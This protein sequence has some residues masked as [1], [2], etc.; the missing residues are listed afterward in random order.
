MSPTTDRNINRLVTALL[1]A[2][3]E[4]G[5]DNSFACAEIAGNYDAPDK[6]VIGSLLARYADE[7]QHRLGRVVKRQEVAQERGRLVFIY[8][9]PP[10]KP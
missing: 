9:G 4:H 6:M 2:I 5:A 8:V 3:D 10:V 1:D 7:I